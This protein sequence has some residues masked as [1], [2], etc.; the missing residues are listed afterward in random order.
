MADVVAGGAQP[1]VEVVAVDDYSKLVSLRIF[2]NV[3]SKSNYSNEHGREYQKVDHT[4][5]V[6][7][8]LI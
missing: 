1:Q 8:S 5:S 2:I 7:K 6:G 3:I 4:L